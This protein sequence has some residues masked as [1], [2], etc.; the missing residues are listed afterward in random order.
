MRCDHSIE[1]LEMRCD[2]TEQPRDASEFRTSSN[3]DE[4][5]QNECLRILIVVEDR[6]TAGKM[7]EHFEGE[8]FRYETTDDASH[9]LKLAATR[10]F[11]AIIVDSCFAGTEGASWISTLR[12]LDLSTP[13]L[14]LLERDDIDNRSCRVGEEANDFLVKPFAVSEL[15]A[16]LQ[17]IA[18]RP[19]G[20]SERLILRF[21]DLEMNLLTRQVTRGGRSIHLPP[22]QFQLLEL[23]MERAGRVVP[24][25]L[26]MERFSVS[27]LKLGIRVVHANV[28][29]LRAEID[30]VHE[31][32]LIRTVRGLGYSL[33]MVKG[34]EGGDRGTR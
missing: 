19:R 21:A 33:Q 11:D 14:L 15:Y 30:R 20:L 7:I 10:A 25:R 5:M 16:R 3:D 1:S 26:I 8:N 12:D 31:A 18:R 32:S 29:R 6:V 17:R 2:L 27:T 34:S 23:L 13:C 28:C 22:R 24:R 4:V 9:G